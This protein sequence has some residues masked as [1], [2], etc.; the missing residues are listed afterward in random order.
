MSPTKT[1]S[2]T[3]AVLN[4]MTPTPSHPTGHR[5]ARRFV[6]HYL[7]M[8]VVMFAGMLVLGVPLEGVLRLLGTSSGAIEDSAPAAMLL[9]MAITM[10]VPMVAWMR[11]HG[12]AWRPCNEMA[13]SMV[14]PALAA[15]ALMGAGAIG[16]GTAMVLEHAVM[17]PAMLVAMLLR[18]DEYACDHA[19]HRAG[20]GDRVPA[21]AKA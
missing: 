20:R 1:T 13:A 5:S 6:R 4:A 16:F 15:M 8:V 18:V 9:Q 14:L 17:L 11:R 2:N 7:E 19:H 21:G 3:K 10:T 12:H